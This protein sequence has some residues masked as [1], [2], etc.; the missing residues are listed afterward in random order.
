MTRHAAWPPDVTALVCVKDALD[1]AARCLGSLEGAGCTSLRIVDDGSDEATSTHLQRFA[2]ARPWVGLVRSDITMGFPRAANVGLR[3]VRS[4]M[5]L[6][7]NS[8]TEITSRTAPALRA[9]L[10]EDPSVAAVGPVSGAASYQSVPTVR[11][12]DGDW[13][14]NE[15]PAGVD[16]TRMDALV[17]EVSSH[18]W[19]YVPFLNGFCMMLA[20]DAVEKIGGFD[21]ERFPDGYGEELDWCL[22][23]VARGYRLRVADDV[24]VLHRKSRSYGHERRRALTS[25]GGETLKRLYGAEYVWRCRHALEVSTELAVLRARLA[26]RLRELE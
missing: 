16:V 17:D 5:C 1:A 22:R 23:A 9:L 20:M 24:Y 10:L 6:L 21:A 26:T 11:S 13:L 15:L 7:L 4:A 12:I 3:E 2:V 8:D 19:P 14:V 18:G 25:H